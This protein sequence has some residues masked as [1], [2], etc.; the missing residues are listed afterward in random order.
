MLIS[1]LSSA[2]CSSDLPPP[3][4]AWIRQ[5]SPFFR[6]KPYDEAGR[7]P[8]S[9]PSRGPDAAVA[10]DGGLHAR[11]LRDHVRLQLLPEAV[12]GLHP[13]FPVRQL[14]ARKSFGVGERVLVRLAFG[15]GRIF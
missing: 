5:A 3:R 15:G 1:D 12:P 10:V 8:P 4:S 14:P 9:C 2:V 6:R 7:P 11:A 13:R